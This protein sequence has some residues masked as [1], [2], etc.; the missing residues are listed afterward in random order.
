MLNKNKIL[1]LAVM[2]AIANIPSNTNAQTFYQCMPCQA[3]T[4]Y[5]NGS[6]AKCPAGTYSQETGATSSNTCRPCPDYQWSDAG[7]TY[8]GK[9]QVLM[10]LADYENKG[11]GKFIANSTYWVN[12]DS[13]IDNRDTY[14]GRGNGFSGFWCNHQNFPSDPSSSLGGCLFG[15]SQN[16]WFIDEFDSKSD[17][18]GVEDQDSCKKFPCKVVVRNSDHSTSGLYA[19]ISP[20][21]NNI[22]ATY[23]TKNGNININFKDAIR[24]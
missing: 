18:I 6:C 5:S 24:W 1:M 9:V 21:D 3:G 15:T 17:V 13:F 8:C 16:M 2:G 11:N 4:Y 7:S 12:I 19:I 10:Q 20:A 22:S 14:Y 23:K